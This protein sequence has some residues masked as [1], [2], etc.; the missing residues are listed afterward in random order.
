[1]ASWRSSEFSTTITW[2]IR[3]RQTTAQAET[4]T[5]VTQR[6]VNT[7]SAAMNSSGRAAKTAAGPENNP[8]TE[9][10]PTASRAQSL[11]TAS[12]AMAE[13]TP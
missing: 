8:Q 3:G 13:T 12:T 4:K 2:N 7:D 9:K 5:S 1:M 6:G 11:T 10:A